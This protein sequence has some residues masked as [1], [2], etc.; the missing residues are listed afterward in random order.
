[1][2]PLLE[3]VLLPCCSWKLCYA[4]VI[5]FIIRAN[6]YDA[7]L[8]ECVGRVTERY[9]TLRYTFFFVSSYPGLNRMK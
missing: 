8:S 2:K 5:Q 1:M 3:V 4:A 7:E 6:D 9:V